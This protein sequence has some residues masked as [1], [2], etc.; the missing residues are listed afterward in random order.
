MKKKM[1]KKGFTLVEL[2]AVVVILLAISVIAVSSI[3]AAM[4]RTKEKE[5]LNKEKIIITHAKDYFDTHKNTVGNNPCVN[6]SELIIEY[7]LDSDTL[8]GFDGSV[9]VDGTKYEYNSSK[10]PSA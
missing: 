7:N 10:C 4:E 8:D 2:L 1:N 9:T 6:V 5:R 3:S